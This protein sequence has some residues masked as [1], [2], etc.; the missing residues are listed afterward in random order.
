MSLLYELQDK[1]FAKARA[2]NPTKTA[3][4]SGLYDQVVAR[5]GD[6]FDT[7]IGLIDGIGNTMNT[8]APIIKPIALS[9]VGG[10]AFNALSG[11]LGGA[12]AASGGTAATGDGMFDWIDTLLGE[13]GELGVDPGMLE[14]G[15]NASGSGF[16]VGGGFFDPLKQFGNS[17]L[18][19][20]T[21]GG[22]ASG[23]GTG[24]TQGRNILGTLFNDPFQAAFNSTPFLLALNEAN[25]QGDD[26]DDVLG[27]I[28]G[29]AYSKSVL[30]PYDM[31]TGLGRTDLMEDQ[32]RRGIR[33]SSFGQQTLGNYDYMRSL[34]RGDLFNRANLASAQLEGNLINTRN[35]NRNLL[36]G[37]GLNASGRLFEPDDKF[38]LRKLFGGQ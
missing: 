20:I 2:A 3:E 27:K 16:G 29:E 14:G 11:S 6:G 19:S 18:R 10:Q 24:Q 4:L 21:G 17:I 26:L 36:L 35:T 33:G 25:R 12:G 31:D 5:R 22:N 7:G 28:N 13:T 23:G 9:M 8:L 32:Q 37:A 30:N 34:G 1:A 38:D 15:F